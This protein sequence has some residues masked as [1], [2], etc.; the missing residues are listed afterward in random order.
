MSELVADSSLVDALDHID[1]LEDLLGKT[2]EDQPC[3]EGQVGS[4][5]YNVDFNTNFEDRNG[6]ITG[7]A[8]YM[9]EA[10]VQTALV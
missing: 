8:R 10:T 4:L 9:E 6:F 3:V 7:V 1:R 2:V 5:Q